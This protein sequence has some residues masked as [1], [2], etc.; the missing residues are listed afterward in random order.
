MAEK[1]I[2]SKFEKKQTT[3]LYAPTWKDPEDS[4]SFFHLCEDMLKSLPDHYNLLIK[5]HPKIEEENPAKLYYYMGKHEKPNVFFV[6]NSPIVYPILARADVYIG[7]FSSIGYDMLT[8]DKPM[9]F[10][11]P[12]K[13]DAK[14][15]NG[16]F[17]F[18]AGIEIPETS[19]SEMFPFIERTLIANKK[20][21]KEIRRKILEYTFEKAIDFESITSSAEQLVKT[22]SPLFVK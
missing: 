3:L 10:L 7:D 22:T 8:F 15:D 21:N 11:N 6:P 14:K 2:F 9:Y 5:L 17:L 19:Y 16:L 12:K 18:Q 4:S 13:R 1:E 20:S